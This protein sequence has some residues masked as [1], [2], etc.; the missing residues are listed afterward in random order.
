MTLVPLSSIPSPCTLLGVR[1]VRFFLEGVQRIVWAPAAPDSSPF[2]HRETHARA[3]HGLSLPTLSTHSPYAAAPAAAA[4]TFAVLGVAGRLGPL[5]EHARQAQHG[6]REEGGQQPHGLAWVCGCVGPARCFQS[7]SHDV[8]VCSA[9]LGLAHAQQPLNHE[10]EGSDH[11]NAHTRDDDHL[12]RAIDLNER[13][14]RKS[15]GDV[16]TCPPPHTAAS[17]WVVDGSTKD[18][19]GWLP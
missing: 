2:D 5:G 15:R 1:G 19:D 11:S 6:K 18:A 13:E 16:P 7:F 12:L 10:A 4:R 17:S 14:S 9:H 8:V 3:T